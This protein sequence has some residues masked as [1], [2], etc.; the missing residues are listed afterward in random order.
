MNKFTN[1]D[2]VGIE[3]EGAWDIKPVHNKERGPVYDGSVSI[4]EGNFKGE[5]RSVPIGDHATA[6]KFMDQNWPDYG[7][8]TCGFHIH[9]SVKSDHAYACLMDRRFYDYFLAQIDAWGKRW[10]IQNREFWNRMNGDNRFCL[11][12]WGP[13]SQSRTTAKY[14]AN[15][16]KHWNFCYLL[17]KTLECR[18]L[19]VFKSKKIALAAMNEVFSIVEDWLDK[20]PEEF[21]TGGA[22]DVVE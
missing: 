3:I 2:R 12:E 11:K 16:Y 8:K 9:I 5:V 10:N 1:I 6:E 13:E 18:V 19:P 17:H 4:H 20:S 22:E 21:S 7:N 15:R 14:Q